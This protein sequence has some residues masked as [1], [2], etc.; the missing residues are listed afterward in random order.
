[1]HIIT[2]ST[3]PFKRGVVI[4][5]AIEVTVRVRSSKL[6]QTEKDTMVIPW[7]T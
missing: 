1:M 2:Y 6:L 4:K 7:K 3:F 5:H